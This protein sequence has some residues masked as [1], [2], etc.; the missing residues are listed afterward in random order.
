MRI[1]LLFIL[2]C[3]VQTAAG[4]P[5]DES[6]FRSSLPLPYARNEVFTDV[7]D[8]RKYLSE[9]GHLGKV[10]KY[11]FTLSENQDVVI[12]HFGSETIEPSKIYLYR[13]LEPREEYE[14]FENGRIAA[15]GFSGDRMFSIG[16]RQYTY[17]DAY[18]QEQRSRA[19]VRYRDY[20]RNHGL[21]APEI[22]QIHTF[23]IAEHLE[24][25]TYFVISE[26]YART[27]NSGYIY[28]EEGML[29]T[30]VMYGS[31]VPTQATLDETDAGTYAEPF[32]YR[33]QDYPCHYKGEGMCHKFRIGVPMDILVSH[34][35]SASA[36]THILLAD[37]DRQPLATSSQSPYPFLPDAEGKYA[38]LYQPQ[39][40]PGTYFVLSA[41]ND[42]AQCIR[43]SV[44]GYAAKTDDLELPLSLPESGQ[45]YLLETCP[46]V[47]L[48]D[49]TQATLARS[50][51]KVTYYDGLGRP[52]QIIHRGASPVKE[53]LVTYM[54]YDV[55]GME[56]ARW[57]AIPLGGSGRYY[58]QDELEYAG[59]NFYQ[60]AYSHSTLQYESNPLHLLS[61]HYG[62]GTVWRNFGR[63]VKSERYTNIKGVDSLD[64]LDYKLTFAGDTLIRIDACNHYETGELQAVRTEDED[65]ILTWEFID[66]QGQTVL[67]RRMLYAVNRRPE[68]LDTYY[69]YDS[70]GN[71]CVVLPPV[72]SSL[73][74]QDL[75]SDDTVDVLRKYAY[76]YRYDSRNRCIARK[77]PGCDWEFFLYDRTD[78]LVCRQDGNDRSRGEWRFSIPDRFGRVCLSGICR[79]DCS[80]FI[81]P[82]S[83][84]VVTAVFSGGEGLYKGYT[85]SGMA[86]E[87]AEVYRVCY[88]D[89]YRFLGQNG[90]PPAADSRVR[91][92]EK[93]GFGK[94][95]EE[96]CKGSLTGSLCRIVGTR[97]TYLGSVC[98][99]DRL[100][101][102]VQCKSDNHLQ[103]SEMKYL[104]YDFTGNVTR[105]LHVHTVAGHP[106]QAEEYLYTYD[107][108]GRPLNTLHRYNGRSILLAERSYDRLGRLKS[109]RCNEQQKLVTEYAYNVRSWLRMLSGSLFSQK[110][111][112]DE[113]RSDS[114][115]A[116]RYGGGISGMDWK[117][118]YGLLRSYNFT[119]DG[120]HRLMRA[121]YRDKESDGNRFGT[122]YTYDTMG[123]IL[124]LQRNGLLRKGSYGTTD[125][126][127]MTYDGNRLVKAEDSGG[128]H[129]DSLGF[130]DGSH[131][132]REYRYDGPGNMT[133]DLNK[134]IE[135]E[136]NFLNLPSII[137]FSGKGSDTLRYFYTPDGS[138]LACI[139]RDM[140]TDYVGNKVYE[141]GRLKRIL[142][143]GGYLEDGRYYF[144]LQDHLGNNRVVADESGNMMQQTHYYP[145]GMPFAD[146]TSPDLQ[147]YKYNGKEQEKSLSWYDY[148]VRRYDAVLGR[149][150]SQDRYAEKYYSLSPYQYAG[151]NPIT[152]IDV[153]GDSLRVYI[154]TKDQGH[155]WLSV[156]EGENMIVY[157]YGR[158]NGTYKGADGSFNSL[159]NGDGVLL[160][161]VGND[162][163]LYNKMKAATDMSIYVIA[164]VLDK[165]IIDMLNEKFNSSS[166]LPENPKSYYFR[167]PSAH[168]I[169]E[170]NLLSNN[171]TTFVSDILNKSGSEVL[172][173]TKFQQTSSFGTWTSIPTSKRFVVPL[174]MQEYLNSISNSSN[175]IYKKK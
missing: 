69:L 9:Y 48:S 41:N 70:F 47:A 42:N 132:E 77:L 167:N 21:P 39:L 97:E 175:I 114:S 155:T 82:L 136:Y 86:L 165:D 74:R 63:S 87:H 14:Y 65:G 111:Y 108:A 116:P 113:V 15:V 37:A 171:C 144:F 128:G 120:Q 137:R 173:G 61:E 119:Y 80:P 6:V 78:W 150:A 152:F 163:I 32:S 57:N 170:Y 20:C 50:M 18:Y 58:Q 8:T 29:S 22:R 122:S 72:A 71:L 45:S 131:S 174:L 92:E 52:E 100:G 168:I 103:G 138:K 88:Y 10:I 38:T 27:S 145:F 40:P 84:R 104:D 7:Q 118:G 13:L 23:L 130:T 141:N 26:G 101:R 98:Y 67:L 156:G 85:V 83:S 124:S 105:Q 24:K 76:L 36:D 129:E 158:Y 142:V 106:E 127:C 55:Y 19:E 112:Y 162:G 64:C 75:S 126:L 5:P 109:I 160:R 60:N 25:G 125:N 1:N 164:D 4:L 107:H 102:L 31:L 139:G 79:M 159:A 3:L 166:A 135:L 30:T 93:E 94:A 134:G 140:R 16:G 44:Q 43:L 81:S 149:F 95:C 62:A 96:G 56:S 148:G 153:N 123:N 91:L 117:A 110:L 115:N 35:G 121:D 2:L 28:M 172:R 133:A 89:D 46:T 17:A 53:D 49:I 154:E 146:S 151:N 169:D 11:R 54:E 12:H 73:L 51:Q 33:T 99:Y 90:F 161:L 143:E 147:P 34:Q 66:R 68:R 157:S 59:R